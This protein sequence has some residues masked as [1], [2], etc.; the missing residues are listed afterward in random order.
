MEDLKDEAEKLTAL[1]CGKR[2]KLVRRHRPEEVLIEFDDGTRLFVNKVAHG[3][4]LS[5]TG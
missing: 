4:E 1:L 2:V 5:V 3:I